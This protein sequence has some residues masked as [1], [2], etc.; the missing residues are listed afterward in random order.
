MKEGLF[1]LFFAFPSS[2]SKT[3]PP[4]K[5]KKKKKKMPGRLFINFYFPKVSQ[6]KFVIYSV[7]VLF[8]SGLENFKLKGVGTFTL[9]LLFSYPTLLVI[10]YVFSKTF[11]MNYANFPDCNFFWKNCKLLWRQTFL[12][13]SSS[14]YGDYAQ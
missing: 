6:K 12:F 7:Y 13:P 2:P 14:F 4:Q 11:C 3:H 9:I 10:F 1:H 8:P 5:K